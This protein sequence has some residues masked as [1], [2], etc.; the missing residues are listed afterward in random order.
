MWCFVDEPWQYRVLDQMPRGIDE[1][2]LERTRG[3]TFAERL[4]AVAELMSLGEALQ[5][6]IARAREKEGRGP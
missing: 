2:Q 1:G 4:D 5:R 6:G 3:L